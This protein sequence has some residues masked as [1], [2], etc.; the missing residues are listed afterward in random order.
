MNDTSIA[1]IDQNTGEL[2]GISRGD[3]LINA[4]DDEGFISELINVRLMI[5]MLI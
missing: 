3:V 2:T 4:I 1:T 5:S